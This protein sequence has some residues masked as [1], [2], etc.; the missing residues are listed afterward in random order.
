MSSDQPGQRRS[1]KILIGFVSSRSGDK[2]IKVTVAYKK[3]H[4][5]YQKV[6]NRQIV[7]HVHDEKNETKVGDQVEVMETRPLSR[8]K[9]WR[10][11]TVL[12][13]AVAAEGA[14]VSEADVAAAVPTKTT[15]PNEA[16]AAATPA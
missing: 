16:V 2:S 13:K 5:F 1:R 15:R 11:I 3:P 4:P 6:V 12:Q 10:V 14:A 7:L 9:R 8:L